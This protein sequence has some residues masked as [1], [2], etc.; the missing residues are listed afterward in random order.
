MMKSYGRLYGLYI[1]LFLVVFSTADYAQSSDYLSGTVFSGNKPDENTK[2]SGVTVKLYGSMNSGTLGSQIGSTTT[3]GNGWYSLLAVSGYEYY[4]IV[5]T[6]LSGYQ[7]VGASSVS[8]TVINSNRIQYSIA[9][10]PLSAQTKT[11]NKFW[12]KPTAPANHS[13]DAV[14]DNASTKKN[15]AVTISVLANDS[16]PDGDTI[17]LQSKTSASHGTVIKSG[18]QIIYTPN[19]GYTGTDQFSYTIS[20]GRGGTDTATVT[21]T[22]TEGSVQ[23]GSIGD[24]IWLD[25]D[26]DGLQDAGEPGIANVTVSLYD[27][28]DNMLASTSTDGSGY[29]LFSNL[30]PDDYYL[31]VTPSSGYQF[32]PQDQGM[33]DTIDSDA[34]A[35]TGRI[36]V[37]SLTGGE[38]RDYM[39]AGMTGPED[40]N[41]DFGDAPN[42]GST[43]LYP[44][45]LAQDGARHRMDP[46]VYLGMQIDTEPDGIPM[47][48]AL[49]DDTDG[50]ND[51]DGVVFTSPLI[52]GTV[53]AVKVTASTYGLLYG[54]IDFKQDGQFDVATDHI[55]TGQA[56]SPG[57]NVLGIAVPADAILGWTYARFRFSKNSILDPEGEAPDGE[58]EDYAIEIQESEEGSVTIIKEAIPADDTQFMLCTHHSSGFFNILCSS[59]SDPSNNQLFFF[60]PGNLL[61][62]QEGTATGWVLSDIQVT[63]DLDNGSVVNLSNQ[64]VTIDFDPGENIV[65]TFKNEKSDE[66][67]FDFG[68]APDPSYPTLLASNGARHIIDPNLYLGSDIDSEPDGLPASDAK[69]D[70]QHGSNDEDGVI[71][72]SIV[73][74]G[75]TVSLKVI[76]SASGYLA[77]WMDFNINGNWQDQ[78]ERI[79]TISSV[80]AGVNHLSFQVP[81]NAAIGQ[82][83]ARFRFTSS[84]HISVDGELPD[85]EVEDYAVGIQESGTGSIT[86]IKDATPKDD[87]PF[88]ITVTYGINGGVAPYRDP[89]ANTS[90]ITNGPAGI[91]GIGEFVTAGWTLKDIIVAGDTDNGSVINIGGHSVN[92]D[93]DDG[94]SITVTFKNEKSDDAA[95]D[96]GDAPSGYP[97]ASHLLDG[98]YLGWLTGAPDAEGGM[99]HTSD[100]SGDDQ[101]G[102][103]DEQGFNV[104]TS[105]THVPGGYW[106][107]DL[108]ITLNQCKGFTVALWIDWNRDFDWNDTQEEIFS[109]STSTAWMGQ[110]FQI[111]SITANIPSTVSPGD[112]FARVRLADGE[113]VALTPD[114]AF[115]KGEIQDHV[116]H[117]VEGPV[118]DPSGGRIYGMKWDDKNGNKIWDMTES[119]LSGWTIWLDLNQ[120]GV[121]D[122][123]D[124]YDITN[125]SGQFEFSGLNAGQYIVG[126]KLKPG[127][128]QTWPGSPATHTMTVDPQKPGLGIMFGNQQTG[129]DSGSSA[130]KWDQSLLFDIM[131][132]DTT[133]YRSRREP[134]VL[135]E[136]IMADNWFCN[137]PKP[138]TCIRWWGAYEDWESL[139]PPENA[140]DYFHIGIWTHTTE[141]ES[142]EFSHPGELIL[143]W[144]LERSQVQEMGI[145]S[146]HD[147][148]TMEKPGSVFQYQF[149]IEPAAW[150]YQ[151]GESNIYWIHIAAAYEE[152]PSAHSWG[153]LTREHYY[154]EDAMRI[155][156]PSD[157]HPGA[158]FEEGMPIGSYWDM[159]YILFTNEMESDFD[160]GD[161]P[162]IG[163]GTTTA[164]NG[165]L[166]LIRPDI[167]LGEQIDADYDGQPHSR[168]TGD[169]EDNLDD[170]DG[171]EIIYPAVV[172]GKPQIQVQ[173]SAHG[174]LNAWMD[175]NQN[176]Q[177]IE[178]DDHIIQNA[179]LEAG[180]HIFEIPVIDNIQA[181]EY[182]SRFRFGSEPYL[183]FRGFA[184]DGEVEDHLLHLD[185]TGVNQTES[186]IPTEYR[187]YQNHPNPFNPYTAITYDISE[188]TAVEIAVYN[189][190]GQRIACLINQEQTPGMYRVIWQGLDMH[191][192]AVSSGV[193]LCRM[194]ARSFQKTTKLIFMR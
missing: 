123:G 115:G 147:S 168:A 148:E 194:K 67:G 43:D 182:M 68:D 188:K 76:A 96:F 118:P 28:S 135:S 40:G 175:V 5:E 10:Q 4:N 127:W 189:L 121:E 165:A 85:G 8:G 50:F 49:G 53:A 122:S 34:D 153:W 13:P 39:D 102:Y 161:A 179:E 151:E 139:V 23:T 20:D 3:D 19:T 100:A 126:E 143:E 98:P 64:E 138:V 152:I 70:D 107:V 103:D 22:V 128:I 63:G 90:T 176:G 144:F 27:D 32:V 109:Y 104:F 187:L 170:E 33:D 93:L 73:T 124:A 101:D 119:V 1:C 129:P 51:E 163:F 48:N 95:Y 44:T 58:V 105:T 7:S 145:K 133:C 191:G 132:D 71:M 166:H 61:S 149:N 79:I 75:Q 177:W 186:V 87:T 91:Y 6:D 80:T 97:S 112:L 15:T 12:D 162:D 16:D 192:R 164:K 84:H 137:N 190:A 185:F 42:N 180:T 81:A 134:S 45:T 69:G 99:Q 171:V 9:S 116:I 155:N 184:I 110:T 11:G 88:W 114:G 106:G 62:A 52:P 158:V 35:A 77:G 60:N 150:F 29:Y 17:T 120:N 72:P 113:N 18:N 92:V 146:Y 140:P 157:P 141:D 94:E 178:S 183:W 54:W 66:E 136:S 82:T 89:S 26:Q 125:G 174:F 59:L 86:I 130:V 37:L 173:V 117:I 74:P 65:I 156:L 172:G 193:Y 142:Y 111:L 41:Y 31:I 131:S 56:L 167:Y 24:W 21:V 159:A 2:I 154:H 108:D 57:S 47:S 25:L 169:D 78:N 181:G 36:D 14:D 83:Y 55:F 38:N 160:F 30:N 46:D